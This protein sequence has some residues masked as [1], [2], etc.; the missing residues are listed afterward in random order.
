MVVKLSGELDLVGE[1]PDVQKARGTDSIYRI[2]KHR[3][4]RWV[5]S[6]RAD[7][8]LGSAVSEVIE[9]LVGEK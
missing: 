6:W 9:D 7:H 8:V 4:G 3:M 2:S 5:S 1:A